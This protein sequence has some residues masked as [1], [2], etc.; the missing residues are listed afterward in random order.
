VLPSSPDV[1]EAWQQIVV[2]QT[3]TGN[4]THDAHLVAVMQ[5]YSIA[6]I[7]TFNTAHFRR[8]PGIMV[9]DPAQVINRHCGNLTL[10]A[11]LSIMGQPCRR[12][13][14]RKLASFIDPHDHVVA[15]GLRND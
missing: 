7:L 10:R 13:V 14:C 9:L 15:R 2:G 6:S 8:F 11:V 4:Q 1:L 5:V 12:S 3:I